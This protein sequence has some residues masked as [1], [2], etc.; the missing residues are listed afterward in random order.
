MNTLDLARAFFARTWKFLGITAAAATVLTLSLMVFG[1]GGTVGL[2]ALVSIYLLIVFKGTEI[3][4]LVAKHLTFVADKVKAGTAKLR[5]W[6]TPIWNDIVGEA[7]AVSG[8][9][10]ALNSAKADRKAAKKELKN[11]RKAVKKLAKNAA[12]ALKA[13]LIAAGNGDNVNDLVVDTLNARKDADAAVAKARSA[14]AAL[15]TA[16]AAVEIAEDNL[17]HAVEAYRNSKTNAS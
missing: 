13:Q 3:Y 1:F 12:K 9:R 11:S 14:K 10:A 16:D 2:I 7:K 15:A 6:W 5:A 4:F 17:H 8:A